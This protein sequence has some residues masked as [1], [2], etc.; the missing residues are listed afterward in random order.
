MW[1]CREETKASSCYI[2]RYP[3]KVSINLINLTA[4]TRPSYPFITCIYGIYLNA[5]IYRRR[6][7]PKDHQHADPRY[8]PEFLPKHCKASS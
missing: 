8:Y 5:V 6:K 2:A 1:S 4:V 3:D 7:H